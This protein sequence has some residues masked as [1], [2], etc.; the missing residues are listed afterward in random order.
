[1]SVPAYF[2][3]HTGQRRE[4]RAEELET[5]MMKRRAAL[6]YPGQGSFETLNK[7]SVRFNLDLIES[8]PNVSEMVQKF[9]T[10]KNK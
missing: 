6:T 2:G 5:K 4:I 7:R 10:M 8:G 1:M 3:I 9:E